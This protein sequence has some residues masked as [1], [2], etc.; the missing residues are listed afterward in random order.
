MTPRTEG[1]IKTIQIVRDANP[2]PSEV[3]HKG[4]GHLEGIVINKENMK[5][6][7]DSETQEMQLEFTCLMHNSRT[8]E[9]HA[10]SV[11]IGLPVFGFFLFT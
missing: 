5:L 11:F 4:S 9:G 8:E 6:S 10:V 2:E 3:Y 1:K 7:N